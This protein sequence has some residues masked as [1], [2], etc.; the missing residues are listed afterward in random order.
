MQTPFEPLQRNYE[1][2]APDGPHPRR[3]P[4]PT[5]VWAEHSNG[6]SS[7]SGVPL[8]S[9]TSRPWQFPGAEGNPNPPGGKGRPRISY[10]FA[11]GPARRPQ[12][13]RTFADRTTL[14]I[15]N[16]PCRVSQER[17]VE[18]LEYLGFGGSFDFLYIPCGGRS[19]SSRSVNLGYGFINFPNPEA[20]MRFAL[21]FNGYRFPGSRG[22]KA[23]EVRAAQTQ[24]LVENVRRVQ[25]TAAFQNQQG[26]FVSPI[27][28]LPGGHCP[29]FQAFAEAIRDGQG[30]LIRL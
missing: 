24:G 13:D 17:F 5:S 29:R 9:H 21:Q 12:P 30:H 8:T 19:R 15:S 16:I 3:V 6:A 25:R 23:C 14:M 7:S 11:E 4:M 10:R 22:L 18:T 2:G 20:C 1:G 28:R 26:R 27:I